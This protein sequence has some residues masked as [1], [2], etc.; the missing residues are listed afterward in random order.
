MLGDSHGNLTN[1]WP[2][3]LQTIPN[4][5]TTPQP[6]GASLVGYVVPNNFTKFYGPNSPGAVNGVNPPPGVKVLSTGSPTEGGIPWNNFGPRF[7]FAYQAKEKLVV[8]GGV[9]LF[10]DRV[11]S[12]KFVHAVEQ[13]DPYALTL[14][15]A[16]GA[17]TPY[18]LANPFPSTPLGF[19]PRYFDPVTGNTS[20]L[21]APFYSMVHTPLTR[22]YNLT[23]QYEFIKGWVLDTGFVGSSSI[24]QANYNHNY[25]LAQLASPSNPI[26]GQTTNTLANAVYR[27]PYLGYQAIGLQGTAYD[28]Y[29]NYNSFQATVRKQ[30][31]HG[32]SLQGAYTWSKDMTV[33]SGDGQTNVNN[34]SNE[35]QQYAPAGFSRPQRFIFNYVYQL[36][37]GSPKGALGYLARGWA[38]SGVTVVQGGT[39]M[40]FFDTAGG[41]AYYGAPNPNSPEGGSSTAQLAPGITYGQIKDPGGLEAHP[42][43][44]NGTFAGLQY[45]NPAAFTA[46]P[47]IGADG[48][49]LFG[50]SG[51][52]IVLGPGQFNF[53]V[54]VT[55]DTRI[56]EKHNLQLRV[57][58]FNLFNHPEFSNPGNARSTPATFGL[59]TSTIANPRLIQIALKYSF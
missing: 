59:I 28:A 1:V 26:N 13:G 42:I 27:T 55:K 38:I 49:T 31:S 50:N 57:E 51:Q 30:F 56:R 12:S 37:F 23:F 48:A 33:L 10:Y 41:T 11:G 9:G 3:L 40:T 44:T 6:S 19:T 24:N 34:A 29:A 32:F 20:S 4:P 5:P 39:P 52:G 54:S 25:N 8:R 53:D 36:P 14:D 7:G 15:Y 43:V 21:N 35:A 58:F 46:P 16:G 47:V 17:A 18:S 22:Q 45:F 2:S